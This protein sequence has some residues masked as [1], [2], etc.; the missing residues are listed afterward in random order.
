MQPQ[1][2]DNRHPPGAACGPAPLRLSLCTLAALLVLDAPA[3]LRSADAMR[4][5][6]PA[7]APSMRI[8]APFA[9]ASRA[10]RLDRPRAAAEAFERRFL[11]TPI[12]AFPPGKEDADAFDDDSDLDEFLDL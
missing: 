12:P 5:D 2:K 11:E 9:K 8:L 3:M 10:L 6:S 7:R 1:D 4:F